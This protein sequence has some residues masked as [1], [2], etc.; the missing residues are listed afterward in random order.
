VFSLSGEERQRT[1]NLPAKNLDDS[2]QLND[3][4]IISGGKG[5]SALSQIDLINWIREVDFLKS[6]P[7][8]ESIASLEFVISSSDAIQNLGLL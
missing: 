3:C 8:V 2:Q 7:T 4:F 5:A 6:S 1:E